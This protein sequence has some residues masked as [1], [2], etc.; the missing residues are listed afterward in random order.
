MNKLESIPPEDAA[1]QVL[2][3]LAYLVLRR[4]LLKIYFIFSYV[5]IQTQIVTPP[6]KGKYDL[7][8]LEPTLPENVST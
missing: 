1:T 2:A 4:I 5:K 6:Y 7:N 8:K 3:F